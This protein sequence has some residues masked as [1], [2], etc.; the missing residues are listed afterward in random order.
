VYYILTYPVSA[1]GVSSRLLNSINPCVWHDWPVILAFRLT[2][3]SSILLGAAGL[4]YLR[5]SRNH[6]SWSDIAS[7]NSVPWYGLAS[8]VLLIR[9]YQ[10]LLSRVS[11]M[12]LLFYL[13]VWV[14]GAGIL[15]TS[16]YTQIL[17]ELF[18]SRQAKGGETNELGRHW[19]LG[20]AEI[21]ISTAVNELLNYVI[22]DW[23][24]S[25][26]ATQ[27]LLSLLVFGHVVVQLFLQKQITRVVRFNQ[28]MYKW[29]DYGVECFWHAL[30]R[31]LN[32]RATRLL[33]YMWWW[34]CYQVYQSLSP[35]VMN[36]FSIN[37]IGLNI[38]Y[39]VCYGSAARPALFSRAI[40]WTL[41]YRLW[42]QELAKFSNPDPPMYTYSKLEKPDHIRLVLLHPRFGFRPISCS[43]VEGPH[44][45]LLMYEAISYTWGNP[46]RTEEI[47]VNG[48]RLKVT[49]SV[50][51]MLATFSSQF[52]PQLLWIDAMC[53]DQDNNEEKAQEVPMMDKIYSH[54][55]FTT[56]FLGQSSLPEA[57]NRVEGDI[58]PYKFDGIRARDDKTRDHFEAARLTFDLFNEFRILKRPIQSMGK[59]VYESYESISPSA[60]RSRQWSALLTF[61]QHPW[62]A[63]VWVVQEVAL[64]P[65]VNVRYG[66]EVIEWKVI[67][68]AVK[69][70]HNLRN[71]RLWLEWSH[72]VQIRHT[73]HSSLYNIIRMDEL[74]ER[75]WPLEKYNTAENITIA[76][77]L[78]QS[79]YFK[80]TNPRD[81]VY[82]LMSLCKDKASLK[83][84][85][86]SPVENVY[87]AAAMELIR[88]R[89]FGLLFGAAGVGN[90]SQSGPVASKL[91]SWVPDW[92]DAPKYSHIH[93]PHKG[94]FTSRWNGLQRQIQPLQPSISP[95]RDGV[96]K[97]LAAVVDIIA[98]V[99]P[100]LFDSTS[101]TQGDGVIDEMCRLWANY[102]RCREFLA[103]YTPVASLYC[104]GMPSQSLLG[105]FHQAIVTDHSVD[106][107][108]WISHLE[109]FRNRP[110]TNSSAGGQRIYAN[111]QSM[112]YVTVQVES[113]CGG[114]RLFVS[115]KGW[116]GLCPPGT[117]K[118]DQIWFVGGLEVPIMLRK[119]DSDAD[120]RYRL[121]GECHCQG[122]RTTGVPPPSDAEM[123]E[124][125]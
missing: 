92:T 22:P 28:V 89:S 83:V 60:S 59:D 9:H 98:D 55:L 38:I 12:L 85:Y 104:Y 16:Q 18:R 56:I 5:L 24:W 116:I 8:S 93:H 110:D 74:R 106:L 20:L 120:K 77:V 125:I 86:L 70:I 117:Q 112:N 62:F 23:V 84:D 1:V 71:F 67:T 122:L 39:T 82:G 48:S 6:F 29:R 4:L 80:A 72:G 123:I 53:I 96:L 2:M 64:S 3:W 36:R 40:G 51:E 13:F 108:E 91:P 44:M 101:G 87:L 68:N 58:L 81:Q 49:K 52:L 107:F 113:Y 43:M 66:D 11:Y 33:M 114:R 118:G 65:A 90:R 61:L 47:L 15:Q 17:L 99:G 105:A 103:A 69:M 73:E 50:Y 30:S 26:I 19:K 111:L 100:A 88:K 31:R 109:Y 94:D 79:F 34:T 63:R 75:F 115:T 76:Q 95:A 54:A 35:E 102:D 10:S 78:E 42:L 37:L 25:R 14:S 21:S 46:E 41:F 124:I 45:R 32:S 97:M 119:A 27:V 57:Q 121:V 7:I